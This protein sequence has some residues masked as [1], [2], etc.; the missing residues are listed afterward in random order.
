MTTKN[1]PELLLP[2]GN[3]EKLAAALRFGADAVYFAGKAFGMRSAADN[4]TMEE[5]CEGA[6]LAHK[7]QHLLFSSPWDR[8][9]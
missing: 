3:P 1:K 2:A 7:Q 8:H 4:F 5:I 6:S 9:L